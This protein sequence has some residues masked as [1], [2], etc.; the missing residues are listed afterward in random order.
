M[1]ECF[2]VAAV[3]HFRDGGILSERQSLDNAD[4][5][6]GFAAECAIKSAL[7][8]LPG[9]VQQGELSNPFRHKHVKELWDLVPLL[10]LQRRYPGLLAVLR[11]LKQAF[12]DWSTD[13]R[14]GPDDTVTAEVL[15]RHREAAKRLLGSVGLTGQRGR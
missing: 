1:P 10:G 14:Y 12:G 3:R 11:G 7:V 6:F 13:Q 4:Q 9:C 5:L 15:D 8:T 2:D